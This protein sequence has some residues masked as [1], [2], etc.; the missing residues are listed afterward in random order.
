MTQSN[1]VAKAEKGELAVFDPTAGFS[2]EENLIG[3]TPRLPKIS[4]VH[5]GQIFKV[6]TEEVTM[7]EIEGIIL[8][9][10]RVNAYWAD[11]FS[12]SGGGTPPD[13]SSM[14]AFKPDMGE[15]IQANT[16]AGC[17][18]NKF[19]SDGG[20]GKACKNMRRIHVLMEGK[21][22]P[23]RLTITSS[24]LKDFDDYMMM[25]TDKQLPYWFVKTKITLEKASNKDGI[26][27]S[28]VKF[29]MIEAVTDGGDAQAILTMREKMSEQMRGEQVIDEEMTGGTNSTETKADPF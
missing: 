11:N 7:T 15:N 23:L 5:Q 22:L 24:S 28:R 21:L 29:E 26:A 17:P 1:K 10:N 18:Q 6:G 19:G 12:D 16:C 4:I 8:D 3:T 14:N 20:R 27:F 2:P 9:S 25:L 13:C